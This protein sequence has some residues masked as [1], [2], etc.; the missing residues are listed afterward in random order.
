MTTLTWNKLLTTTRDSN[1]E[2]SV[3]NDGKEMLKA[4]QTS[5]WVKEDKEDNEQPE[6]LDI[7]KLVTEKLANGQSLDQGCLKNVIFA[8]HFMNFIIKIA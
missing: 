7:L 3:R 4:S 2:S 5:M 1:K 8:T 6:P